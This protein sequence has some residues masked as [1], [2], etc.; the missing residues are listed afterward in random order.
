MLREAG[1]TSEGRTG[2]PLNASADVRIHIP[3]NPD[4]FARGRGLRPGSVTYLPRQAFG[5]LGV[6][7]LICAIMCPLFIFIMWMFFGQE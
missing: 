2:R 6:G 4:R 1:G 3:V 7:L 5:V